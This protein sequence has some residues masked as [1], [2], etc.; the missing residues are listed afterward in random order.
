MEKIVT[1]D[2]DKAKNLHRDH[3]R[4]RRIGDLK[5]L[6]LEYQ[7][8]D[9]VQDSFRKSEIAR[10]KQMLRDLPL[11]LRIEQASSMEQLIALGYHEL[12]GLEFF[13]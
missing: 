7:R 9:E 5:K 3:L 2:L 12:L 10:K 1:I 13:K 6:D 4:R 8:A 11:D